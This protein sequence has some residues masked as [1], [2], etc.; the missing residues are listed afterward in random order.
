MDAAREVKQEEVKEEEKKEEED[1]DSKVRHSHQFT[2]KFSNEDVE[3]TI[4]C[5]QPHTVLEMDA[6]REVKIKKEEEEEEKKE[7]EDAD[8]KV[9]HS[10]QF[11]VKFSNEDV[12]YT[13]D[14]DQPRTVLERKRSLTLTWS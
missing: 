5:D 14:C 10:H 2:V 13:I 3:Y 7:E 11:T 12:E 9:R 4:D 6:A 1:A 8:S